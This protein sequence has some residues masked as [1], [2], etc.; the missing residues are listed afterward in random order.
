MIRFRS[1]WKVRLWENE[2]FQTP[3]DGEGGKLTVAKK[4]AKNEIAKVNS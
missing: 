3:L 1:V 2:T 4:I